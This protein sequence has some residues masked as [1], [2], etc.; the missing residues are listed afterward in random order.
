MNEKYGRND[1]TREWLRES[2]LPVPVV[3]SPE[4]ISH[5]MLSC[6]NAAVALWLLLELRHIQVAVTQ[7]IHGS[8]SY[9]NECATIAQ[10]TRM[11]DLLDNCLRDGRV[12]SPARGVRKV[13]I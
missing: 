8:P 13:T 2:E 4:S 6:M 9:G 1:S 7:P 5:I 11:F 10:L 3:A 12:L